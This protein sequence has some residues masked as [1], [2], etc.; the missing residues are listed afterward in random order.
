MLYTISVDRNNV[1][2][3]KHMTTQQ[4]R[5][6]VDE[7]EDKLIDLATLQEAQAMV[8]ER[9]RKLIAKLLA[10]N[11]K[12]QKRY[13]MYQTQIKENEDLIKDQ[14]IIVKDAV[15]TLGETVTSEKLQA[16]W[17]K[18]R[19]SWNTEQLEGLA[20]VHKEILETQ[21]VGDPSVSIKK[22]KS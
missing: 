11:P 13:D 14:T 22:V 21:K 2:E 17:V 18:G 20:K 5:S 9:Q 10:E 7:I 6:K 12:A 19:T 4:K 3:E 1:F 16:V 8:Q 15:L